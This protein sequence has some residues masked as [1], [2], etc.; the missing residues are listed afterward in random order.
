M[1]NALRQT[2]DFA[3]TDAVLDL[4]REVGGGQAAAFRRVAPGGGA[5]K[6]D[7]S[8]VSALDADSETRLRDGL[9]GLLPMAGFLG[10]ES[11]RSGPADLF[12]VVDPLD[13]TTNFISGLR[14]FAISVALVR[15][16]VGE[17]GVV[18]SP[19]DGE[20]FV[21][22]RGDGAWRNG[23]ALGA[24]GSIA[25]SQS[26]IG[27]GLPVSRPELDSAGVLGRLAALWH[28]A[29]DL[30]CLGCASLE[31]CYVAAGD[32]QGFWEIGLRA[33]DV[34]AAAVVLGE[35]GCRIADD[36]GAPHSLL[37]SSGMVAAHPGA[38]EDLVEV[39]AGRESSVNDGLEA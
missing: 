38:F 20:S 39:I 14:P 13:G 12:W 33:W 31:L 1:T 17:L 32:L 35:T 29:R 21:A 9:T 6:A 18:Y 4:C 26:V 36:R 11:G 34:A 27:M 23:R 8:L 19:S 7:G 37:S 15:D 28:R 10:E 25:L 24:V 22:V 16:G 5:A 3:L 30:R 2:L